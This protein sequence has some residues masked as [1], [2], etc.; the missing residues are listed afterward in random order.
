LVDL[1]RRRTVP[2]REGR[3]PDAT[4]GDL[5]LVR[6]TDDDRPYRG[7][8]EFEPCQIGA[9]RATRLV[10]RRRPNAAA[11]MGRAMESAPEGSRMSNTTLIIIILIILLLFGG[12]GYRRW[13][14]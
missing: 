14:R 1:V 7:E 12:F 9:P 10:S 5:L 6:L 2:R 13:R 3:S 8:L 4:G 11:G